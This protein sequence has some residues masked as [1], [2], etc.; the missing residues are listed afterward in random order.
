MSAIKVM[1]PTH[2]LFG[3]KLTLLSEQCGRGKAFIAV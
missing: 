2:P 3:Q 1:D